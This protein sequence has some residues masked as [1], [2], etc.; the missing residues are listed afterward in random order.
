VPSL[1]LRK[2]K[3][4]K[5]PVVSA[6][7][8]SSLQKCVESVHMHARYVHTQLLMKATDLEGGKGS[9]PRAPEY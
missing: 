1:H 2:P 3:P 9:V 5:D 8:T 6:V 4:H 7:K